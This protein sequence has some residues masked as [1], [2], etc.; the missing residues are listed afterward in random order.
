M[1][2]HHYFRGARVVIYVT[3]PVSIF[4]LYISINIFHLIHFTSL[5]NGHCL[6]YLVTFSPSHSS[7]VETWNVSLDNVTFDDI[8]LLIFDIIFSFFFYFNFKRVNLLV[9]HRRWPEKLSIVLILALIYVYI[10]IF[11]L[12]SCAK[13]VALF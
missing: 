4:L 1:H 3:K 11:F 13:V 6:L 8:F 10:Y 12:S 5:W 7:L 2:D 9:I